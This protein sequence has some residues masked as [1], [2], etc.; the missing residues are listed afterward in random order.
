VKDRGRYIVQLPTRLLFIDNN[1]GRLYPYVQ[2]AN[3]EI[4][5]EVFGANG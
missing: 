4:I 5:F 3:V 1:S 2:G